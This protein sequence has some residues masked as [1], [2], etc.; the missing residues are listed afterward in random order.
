MDSPSKEVTQLLLDWKQGNHTALDQ[1]T[2]LVYQELRRLAQSYLRRERSDHTLQATALIHEAYVR[3]VDQGQP[4]WESR[5]HFF[6]IA[7]Q[8]MRQI[9]VDHARSNRAAKRGGGA[10]KLSLNEALV[11]SHEKSRTLVDLDD[12]LR[13]LAG[14]DERK[15][16][17]VELRYF[18]GLS[19]EEIGEAMGIS[20]AT[21]GRELRLASAWLRRAMTSGEP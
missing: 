6:G 13:E 1:L 14:F 5:I 20:V 17:I 10:P 4:A 15:S 19:I 12:A 16:R 11:F 18:G 7:A 2:P 21:V 3:L 9:L 8:L